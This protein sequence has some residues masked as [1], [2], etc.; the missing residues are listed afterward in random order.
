MHTYA[1]T[2]TRPLMLR[3]IYTFVLELHTVAAG[4]QEGWPQN[5]CYECKDGTEPIKPQLPLRCQRLSLSLPPLCTLFFSPLLFRLSHLLASLFANLEQ[6]SPLPVST[7]F[8]LLSLIKTVPWSSPRRRRVEEDKN[9][10]SP[11]RAPWLFP[12]PS[13][14]SIH[15]I[16]TFL[17]ISRDFFFFFASLCSSLTFFPLTL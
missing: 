3:L 17:H 12:P 13:L 9:S 15:Q 6:P 10:S 1:C 7:S 11:A 16:S 2:S 8:L 5:P 4:G 14:R